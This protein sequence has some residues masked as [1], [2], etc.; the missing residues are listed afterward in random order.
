[1]QKCI[2]RTYLTAGKPLEPCTTIIR[3]L[4]YDGLTTQG[5][6]VHAAKHPS[7][8]RRPYG[9]W[10]EGECSQTIPH[11]GFR[12]ENKGGNPEYLNHKEYGIS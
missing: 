6:G 5:L 10:V 11:E 7:V 9:T 2:V 8:S 12:L 4:D 3:K 1:M